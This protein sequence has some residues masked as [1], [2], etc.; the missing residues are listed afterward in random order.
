[1]REFFSY[2]GPLMRALTGITTLLILNVLTLV[3]S[4]PLFTAGAA[5]ASLN[6]CIMKMVD[7]ED[8][9]IV[10]MYFSQFKSNFKSVTP[11]WLV[12]LGLGAFLFFDYQVFLA[13]AESVRMVAVVLI[14]MA[15]L[16]WMLIYVWFFPLAAKFENGFAAKFKNAL[17]MA[18]GALPQ[19]VGMVAI[20]VVILFVLCRSYRLLPLLLFFGLSLPAYLSSF[21]YYPVINRQIEGDEKDSSD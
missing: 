5:L 4:L 21:L 7:D 20:W 2:D 17:I 11:A 13:S 3:C 1:M 16:V 10:R 6:Y 12:L 9:G 8:T 15:G 14:Y 18:V 19:T